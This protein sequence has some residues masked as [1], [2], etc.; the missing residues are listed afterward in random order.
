[1]R[2]F[3]LAAVLAAA[4]TTPR[5]ASQPAGDVAAPVR[6][7]PSTQHER[8]RYLVHHVAMCV[9]CHSPRDRNGQLQQDRLLRGASVPVESP[10][11]GPRWAFNAPNIV[12]AP[13]YDRESFVRL[14]TT[15]ATN[16]GRPA[17]SP[18][19]PYRMTREDAEAVW[20]YLRSM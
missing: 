20:T 15:G 9:Q 2:I 10:F 14:L 13:G 16:Q 19:P 6:S 5:L 18:M 8:G 11:L 3:L 7:T 1:M 17:R 4:V 12:R